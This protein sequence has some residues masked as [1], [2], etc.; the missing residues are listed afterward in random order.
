LTTHEFSNHNCVTKII[1][2]YKGKLTNFK[3]S[4]NKKKKQRK[5][6]G[7]AN[8]VAKQGRS[9]IPAGILVDI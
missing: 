9:L 6:K 7:I 1:N 5:N 8:K 2:K 4:K 3:G